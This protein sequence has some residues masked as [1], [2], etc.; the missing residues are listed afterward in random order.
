MCNADLRNNLTC[1]AHPLVPGSSP[2]PTT[3]KGVSSEPWLTG[4]NPGST[5][6]HFKNVLT[7]IRTRF[8]HV[9]YG[10]KVS[11]YQLDYSCWSN[12]NGIVNGICIVNGIVNDIVSDIVNGIVNEIGLR[13]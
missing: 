6:F 12:I 11:L 8:N 1:D 13:V 4:L 5:T 2:A 3:F 7:G 10:F 9:E